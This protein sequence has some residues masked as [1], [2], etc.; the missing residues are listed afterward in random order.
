MCVFVCVRACV[1]WDIHVLRIDT[2]GLA[3][4]GVDID[5]LACAQKD[6]PGTTGLLEALPAQVSVQII[7][8]LAQA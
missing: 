4:V 7:V 6:A 3:R 1:L 2:N 8:Q 5:G